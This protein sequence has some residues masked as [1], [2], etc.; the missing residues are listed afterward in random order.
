VSVV[1]DEL[2]WRLYEKY[3]MPGFTCRSHRVHMNGAPR[4]IKTALISTPNQCCGFL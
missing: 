1:E 2:L 4:Q 3:Q